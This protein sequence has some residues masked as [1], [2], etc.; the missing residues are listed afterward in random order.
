[1]G[2]LKNPAVLL[3]MLGILL[4]PIL[5]VR[6]VPGALII[7]IAVITLVGFFVPAQRTARW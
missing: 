1:M 2:S 3:T 6:R 5:V 4:T 7:A